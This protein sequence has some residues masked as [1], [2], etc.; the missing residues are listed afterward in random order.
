MSRVCSAVLAG[1]GSQAVTLQG[2]AGAFRTSHGVHCFL[3]VP[4]VCLCL[5][6][7]EGG[8]GL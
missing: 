1:V 3:L 2:C 4:Q 8:F 7:V 6:D 5:E